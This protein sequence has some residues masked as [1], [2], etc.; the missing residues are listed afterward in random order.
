MTYI[1][2]PFDKRQSKI[3]VQINKEFFN[4]NNLTPKSNLKSEHKKQP[5]EYTRETVVDK[6]TTFY[7]IYKTLLGTKPLTKY[8]NQ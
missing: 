6:S 2:T 5:S 3:T 1:D 7:T 8:H 4:S